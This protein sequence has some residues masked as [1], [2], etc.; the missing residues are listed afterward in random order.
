MLAAFWHMIWN[1]AKWPHGMMC[2]RVKQGCSDQ[3]LTPGSFIR[4]CSRHGSI[5]KGHWKGHPLSLFSS[6]QLKHQ[7]LNQSLVFIQTLIVLIDWH[8]IQISIHWAPHNHMVV[9]SSWQT[10]VLLSALMLRLVTWV[11]EKWALNQVGVTDCKIWG[12]T[13]L[14]VCL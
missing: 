14:S 6:I 1:Y 2:T 9:F 11:L 13:H 5:D 10:A 7:Q 3:P 12:H 4:L 8:V